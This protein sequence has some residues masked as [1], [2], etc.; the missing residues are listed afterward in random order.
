MYPKQLFL[1]IWPKHVGKYSS[2]AFWRATANR[3]WK[4]GSN[5]Y[6]TAYKEILFVGDHCPETDFLMSWYNTFQFLLKYMWCYSRSFGIQYSCT[7]KCFHISTHTYIFC[8][9]HM[10]LKN[11]NWEMG[12]YEQTGTV[13]II[14]HAL[15]MSNFHVLKMNHF[16][17]LFK[18]FNCCCA[19]RP[20]KIL[21]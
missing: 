13:N 21:V 3:K 17:A 11:T 8:P 2:S 14:L 4:Y 10:L 16:Q 1:K 9:L 19:T 5:Y 20:F 6:I 12:E 18:M 15:L 7:I